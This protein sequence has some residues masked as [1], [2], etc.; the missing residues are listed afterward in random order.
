MSSSVDT[1]SLTAVTTL[2]R[3]SSTLPRDKVIPRTATTGLKLPV[4]RP[5]DRSPLLVTSREVASSSNLLRKRNTGSRS[6]SRFSARTAMEELSRSVNRDMT[7]L[8]SQPN[9]LVAHM[10]RIEKTKAVQRQMCAL[11]VQCT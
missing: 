5:R 9:E 6:T 11:Q 8:L 10:R 1:F 2:K 3:S 4:L 7:Q